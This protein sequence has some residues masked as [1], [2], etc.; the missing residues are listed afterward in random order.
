MKTQLSNGMLIALIINIV[1]AKGIGVTQGI[2]A[3]QAG[4][5]MWIITFLSAMICLGF[6][7]ITIFII[8]RSPKEN[9][10]EQAGSMVGKCGEKVVAGLVFLF[11]VGAFGGVMITVVYHLQ[12][13]FLPDAPTI[14]FIIVSIVVGLYGAYAG[15]EVIARLSM[16]GV[17]SIVILNVLILFGSLSYFEIRHFLPIMRNGV[18]KAFLITEH[19]NADWAMAIMMVS[20]LL[21]MVKEQKKWVGSGVRGVVYGALFIVLWPILNVGV[22][23]P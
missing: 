21:P 11:F 2:I 3:R 22:L 19:H 10:M 9:M 8:R 7:V 17:F 13:Y 18:M 15:I 16:L 1:Y 5:D 12:D 14:L 20:I 6:M 23:S 4:G